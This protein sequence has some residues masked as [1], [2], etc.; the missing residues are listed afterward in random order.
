MLQSA[1]S[2]RALSLISILLLG[3]GCAGGGQKASSEPPP[4]KPKRPPRRP[5]SPPGQADLEAAVNAAKRQDLDAAIEFSKQAIS[6]N[7]QLEHAYLLY[8]SS[9]A[10]KGDAA[11]EM[12][13]YEQGLEA[14]PRSVALKKALGLTLLSKDPQQAVKTL[15]E[16]NQLAQGKDPELLADL[17][18][19]YIFVERLDEGEKLAEEAVQIDPKCFQCRMALGEIR[20]VSRKFE[21]AADA[22]AAASQ[23][24]PDEPEATK[25]LA[26]ATYLAGKKADAFG[27]YR[28]QLEK[29]PDDQAFRFEF[30][31][32]LLDGGKPKQAAEQLEALL[33]GNPDEPNLLKMLYRAQKQAKNRKG[34]QRTMKRLK[35]LGVKP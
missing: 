13:A 19:A 14:L 16:A 34:A 24:L 20:L 35:A 1:A 7:P 29:S 15:E 6:R 9:C 8:G 11:C 23:L 28:A 25:K 22:Y 2:V 4:A 33:E 31:K 18:Y 26:K 30:A 5:G 17:A 10:M 27:M 21:D 32:V 12:S 3:A